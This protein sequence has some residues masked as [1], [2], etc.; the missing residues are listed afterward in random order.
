LINKHHTYFVY[1]PVMG[2]SSFVISRTDENTEETSD[3]LI[4]FSARRAENNKSELGRN[5]VNQAN[6]EVLSL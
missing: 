5:H 6:R 2:G 3:S 4:T 1:R